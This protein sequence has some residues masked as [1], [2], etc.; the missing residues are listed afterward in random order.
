M[1]KSQLSWNYPPI[2]IFNEQPTIKKEQAEQNLADIFHNIFEVFKIAA[3]Y[4]KHI[5]RPQCSTYT[6]QVTNKRTISKLHNISSEIALEIGV[7][8]GRVWIYRD[9]NSDYVHIDVPNKHTDPVFL[10][11]F[12]VSINKKK[13]PCALSVP[14]GINHIN[15][16]EIADLCS[17]PNVFIVGSAQTGKT[18]LCHS[19][20]CSLLYQKSSD[21]L[22]FILIDIKQKSLTLYNDIPHL[23]T[24]VITDLTKAMTIPELVL[25]E[26]E[27]RNK[28]LKDKGASDIR[29]YNK[30][31][32]QNLIPHIVIFIDDLA[33]LMATIPD[34]VEKF[35]STLSKSSVKVGIHLIA[36]SRSV[37]SEITEKM[38]K[39][40]QTKI[41]FQVQSITDSRYFI[42]RTDAEKLLDQGDYFYLKDIKTGIQ[43]MQGAFISEKEV[44]DVVNYIVNNNPKRLDKIK[45]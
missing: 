35:I 10:E 1:T 25:S 31:A 44:M 12:I 43:R 7:R 9:S 20:I 41:T 42:E 28:K 8:S 23:Y 2:N 3:K 17:M 5:H 29:E 15:T 24:P 6:F 37:F 27:D 38:K 26:M 39:C 36:T 18:T 45:L 22:Q 16:L 14:L 19:W 11:Q 40:V 32:K 13:D 21:Q 30:S 34:T 4:V 33:H